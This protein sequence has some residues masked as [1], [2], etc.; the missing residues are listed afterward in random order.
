MVYYQKF[1]QKD[2]EEVMKIMPVNFHY[3]AKLEFFINKSGT[4]QKIKF[5]DID[6]SNCNV[7]F[8]RNLLM[9]LYDKK[10]DVSSKYVNNELIRVNTKFTLPIK[11]RKVDYVV[12]CTKKGEHIKFKNLA[13]E[14]EKLKYNISYEVGHRDGRFKFRVIS[15]TINGITENNVEEIK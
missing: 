15:T 4:L 2:L 5:Y 1:I 10:W 13:S 11:V 12:V 3:Y 9:E 14:D 6:S 8:R 7:S